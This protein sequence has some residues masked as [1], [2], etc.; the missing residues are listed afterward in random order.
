M[1]L[2]DVEW[3][4]PES[5]GANHQCWLEVEHEGDHECACQVKLVNKTQKLIFTGPSPDP[6]F[7]PIRDWIDRQV[8]LRMNAGQN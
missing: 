8:E 2:C 6:K 7:Q 1:T 5:R 3:Q 4:L